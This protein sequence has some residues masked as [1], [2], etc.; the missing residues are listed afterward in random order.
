[1]GPINLP[2]QPSRINEV[3][4]HGPLYHFDAISDEQARLLG[5]RALPGPRQGNLARE[6]GAT[7][8]RLKCGAL[9]VC[10]ESGSPLLRDRGVQ[11]FI[12]TLLDP[13]EHGEAVTAP[14]A[15]V[16]PDEGWGA[17]AGWIDIDIIT[18]AVRCSPEAAEALRAIHPRYAEA[19]DLE[20]YLRAIHPEDR[21]KTRAS[22]NRMVEWSE[23][24]RF[25]YR[26]GAG[27]VRAQGE[28]L[29]NRNGFPVTARVWVSVLLW[30]AARRGESQAAA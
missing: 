12:R 25:E 28:I 23:T 15:L 17:P 2:V 20:H 13:Q 16:D 30:G 7:A 11:R 8:R 19:P 10:I 9:H 6:E 24:P 1:M 21:A 5:L 22:I 18:H 29:R 3:Y 26:F 14:L 27:A 4:V